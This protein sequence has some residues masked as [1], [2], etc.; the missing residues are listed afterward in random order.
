MRG[1]LLAVVNPDNT[2]HGYNWTFAFPMLLFIVIT[3]ALYLLFSRPH[4]VPGHGMLAAARARGQARTPTPEPEAARAAAVAAGF[5][6]AEGG[7]AAE[8]EAEPVGAHRTV[9]A[10]LPGSG[11]GQSA[12][13]SGQPGS[14]TGLSASGTGQPGSVADRD[15]TAAED[16]EPEDGAAATDSDPEASE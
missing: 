4:Q 7:G 3:G 16:G 13:G 12:G 10:D 11:T 5:T 15:A 1:M 6:T 2:P 8:S 14:G 9:Q